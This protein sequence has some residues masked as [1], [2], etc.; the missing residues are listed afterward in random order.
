[1]AGDSFLTQVN[2]DLSLTEFKLLSKA[3][4]AYSLFKNFEDPEFFLVLE[5]ELPNGDK[6]SQVQF[7]RYG[8]ILTGKKTQENNWVYTTTDGGSDWILTFPPKL[9]SADTFSGSK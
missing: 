4:S 6:E 2:N 8:F 7:L 9:G 3:S 5:K 1:M